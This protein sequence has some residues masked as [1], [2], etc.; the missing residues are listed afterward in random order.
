M[1]VF[2]LPNREKI[3]NL[4]MKIILFSKNDVKT[5]PSKIFIPKKSP[6]IDRET[7]SI[8]GNNVQAPIDEAI[9]TIDTKTGKIFI[10]PPKSDSKKPKETLHQLLARILVE[11]RLSSSQ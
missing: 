7:A 1:S 3:E 4:I 5:T 9:E 11:D 8:G 6:H 2:C 10:L